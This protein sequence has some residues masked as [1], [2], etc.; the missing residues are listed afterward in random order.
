MTDVTVVLTVAEVLTAARPGQN[1]GGMATDEPENWVT[2]QGWFTGHL[3]SD[4]ELSLPV[5]QR[6][7]GT[8]HHLPLPGS[9]AQAVGTGLSLI[10]I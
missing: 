1:A 8:S 7:R 4:T 9:P 6:H 2:V 10:H 5:S 3:P